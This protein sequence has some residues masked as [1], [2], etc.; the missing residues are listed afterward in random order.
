MTE[1][2]V[3]QPGDSQ[4]FSVKYEDGGDPAKKTVLES[5]W[6]HFNRLDPATGK[7]YYI[8]YRNTDQRGNVLVDYKM[9]ITSPLG[10]Y[11]VETFVPGKNA[12]THKAVFTVA[13]NVRQEGGE[14]KY[15]D[16]L[17]VIDMGAVSDIWVRWNSCLTPKPIHSAGVCA[18]T[19]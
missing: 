13:N 17:A 16:T 6:K 10:L 2:I 15:D 9:P 5:A 19:T 12:T 11:R 18:S 4:F 1:L 3:I 8:W 7:T 14:P